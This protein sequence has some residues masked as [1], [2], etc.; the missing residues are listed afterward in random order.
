MELTIEKTVTWEAAHSLPR[1]PAGHKCRRLHGHTY[2]LTA[3]VRGEVNKEGIVWDFADL[4]ALMQEHIVSKCDHRTLNDVV[5]N[6]TGE[7]MVLWIVEGL[8][9]RLPDGLTLVSVTLSEGF[10]NATKWTA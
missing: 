7:N 10:N 1:M 8:R 2:T 3:G 5:A 6:P 9:H 4:K